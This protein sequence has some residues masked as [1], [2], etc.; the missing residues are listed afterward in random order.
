[1]QGGVGASVEVERCV[2]SWNDIEEKAANDGH[3]LYE[4]PCKHVFGRSCIATWAKKEATCPTCREEFPTSLFPEARKKV[5]ERQVDY[6]D[7]LISLMSLVDNRTEPGTSH[8]RG[9]GIPSMLIAAS[10]GIFVGAAAFANVPGRSMP[11]AISQREGLNALANFQ[12]ITVLPRASS[13]QPGTLNNLSVSSI[14]STSSFIRFGNGPELP[15]SRSLSERR[16]SSVMVAS[17]PEPSRSIFERGIA[18]VPP[19]R[20][21]SERRVS[22]VIDGLT[23]PTKLDLL[24]SAELLRFRRQR[25]L[26]I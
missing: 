20:P 17:E 11:A 4:L 1:M 13:E 9:E 18:T 5:E 2:I 8:D 15:P 7:V 12:P 19:S 6:A 26:W 23:S 25:S 22:S 24:S 16:V 10:I 14:P 21:L 3:A